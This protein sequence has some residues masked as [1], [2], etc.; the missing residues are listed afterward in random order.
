MR[1]DLPTDSD[2][3]PRLHVYWSPMP[4][5]VHAVVLSNT[6]LS[7]DYS[8]LRARCRR[9]SRRSAAR[10]VRDGEVADGARSRCCD[11]PSR[12]SR[13]C[14]TTRAARPASRCSTSES[15]AARPCSSTLRPGDTVDCLGPLGRPFELVRASQPRLDGRWRR[16]AGA[17]R[18]A[19]R[20]PARAR[21]AP[22]PVLRRPTRRRPALHGTCF[23]R[24]RPRSSCARRRTAAAAT[25]G[26]VTVPLARALETHRR[27]R[28]AR[29]R[30]RPD[31]DDAR[32]RRPLPRASAAA[33][34]CR[35]SR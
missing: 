35:S 3:R 20:A 19:R 10:S 27:R 8:V 5:D 7:D 28:P 25:T 34:T 21:R 1:F 29:L 26:F 32:R 12:S 15:G 2:S 11:V 22:A 30:L 18:D 14:G 4:I 6:R 24:P 13:C 33:A 16:R 9:P 31:A 23:E 17:V